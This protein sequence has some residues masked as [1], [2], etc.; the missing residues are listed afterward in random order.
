M[1]DV[2]KRNSCRHLLTDMLH[3]HP[4]FQGS[5]S[6]RA[7]RPSAL[8]S[9]PHTGQEKQKGSGDRPALS[10]PSARPQGSF[11]PVPSG[12]EAE[13]E[14]GLVTAC[15]LGQGYEQPPN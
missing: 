1:S 3:K 9:P 10:S 12:R 4:E 13:Y 7:L 8:M 14:E 5:G 15:E 6:V 2:A 11:F